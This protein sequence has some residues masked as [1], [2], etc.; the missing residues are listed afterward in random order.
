MEPLRPM[1]AMS[2]LAP[3]E[4]WWSEALGDRLRGERK[5]AHVTHSSEIRDFFL[6]NVVGN[7]K[8]FG[9]ASIA[10]SASCKSVEE[11]SLL[12]RASMA[13]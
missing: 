13:R 9:A 4:R 12:S 5:T 10:S 1:K 7:C 6:S 8:D 3:A 2:P 11:K